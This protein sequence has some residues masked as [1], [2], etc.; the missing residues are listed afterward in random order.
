V[1]T[2]APGKKLLLG[3]LPKGTPLSK[4]GPFLYSERLT[5]RQHEGRTAG[6]GE[7]SRS[8]IPPQNHP[9]FPSLS[10]CG[11]LRGTPISG[12]KVACGYRKH[13]PRELP[14][15]ATVTIDTGY[16]ASYLAQAHCTEHNG[17]PDEGFS[18]SLSA[19]FLLRLNQIRARPMES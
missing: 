18:S 17:Y 16:L 7:P 8:F 4:R 15:A 13:A 3:I 19:M 12:S 1:A 11:G 6:L 2:T 9:A 14:S 5:S 10:T